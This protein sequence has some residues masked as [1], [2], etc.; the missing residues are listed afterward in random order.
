MSGLPLHSR[1]A[2]RIAT[3][4]LR[5][6]API[7][8][9]GLDYLNVENMSLAVLKFNKFDPLSYLSLDLDTCG[10]VRARRQ[11]RRRPRARRRES[12]G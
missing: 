5:R 12:G 9:G 10:K 7:C 2:P 4:L 1:A 3:R 6:Y 8:T 11:R